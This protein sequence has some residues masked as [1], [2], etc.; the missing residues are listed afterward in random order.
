MA[1]RALLDPRAQALREA[2]GERRLADRRAG[3]PQIAELYAIEASVR[4]RAP[5]TR[6]AART[7]LAAPIVAAFRPWLEAQLSRIP[8]ASKLAEDIRYTLG[9]WP[10]LTRFL[11]DGR[12]E[13]ATSTASFDV[14]FK[15]VMVGLLSGGFGP[16]HRKRPDVRPWPPAALRQGFAAGHGLFRASLPDVL[17][18]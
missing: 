1:A 8:R 2:A 10:G 15:V 16:N 9:I 17:R 14:D 13:L 6:L 7:K 4:G 12:L 5:E 11:E 18:P 3:P